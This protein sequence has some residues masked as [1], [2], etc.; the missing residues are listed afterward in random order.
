MNQNSA[1]SGIP[2]RFRSFGDRSSSTAERGDYD[3]KE[4]A[5]LTLRE[6]ERY[7]GMEIGGR[8]HQSIHSM[9]KRPP[10]AVWNEHEGETPLR[11]PQDRL[12]F[13]G[14]VPARRRAETATQRHSPF[15]P[16]LLVLGAHRGCRL[17]GG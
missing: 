11:M 2:K 5:T 17:S 10:I 12:Q 7:I 16:P 8:Y 6:L 4:A 13:L 15:W 3:S 14:L 9:L 1:D